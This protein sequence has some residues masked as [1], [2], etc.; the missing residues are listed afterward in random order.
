MI[1]KYDVIIIGGGPGGSTAGA[2]L[3]QKSL[4]VALF[5]RETYPRFHIGESLLPAS[6]PILKQSGFYPTLSNGKYIE[7]Y[8]ARFVD[9]HTD[10]EVYFGFQDG[11]SQDLPMAFEVERSD[12][13]RDILDH[14]RKSGVDVFQPERVK[15][16][17]LFDSH[18]RV[19]TNRDQYEAKFLIDATGRD[20]M[21]GKQQKIRT[22]NRDLNN[23]AVFAHF[24]GVKRLEGKDEGDILIGLLPDRAWNWI[25]PFKGEKTSV[26]VVCSSSQFNGGADLLDYLTTS[27]S[28]S[29]RV[30]D[31]MK[32]AEKS[33][34][35]T[36][37]SN[38]SHTCETLSGD[39]WILI[40]DAA[41]FL[42]P[43]FSSGVH[44]SL[45]SAKFASETII[46]ALDKGI[47]LNQENL[48]NNYRDRLFLGVKR[49][50]NLISMFYQGGFVGQMKKTN[51]L[52][53]TR[54]GF[55]SAVAGD[56]WNENNFLF[57]K[58]IL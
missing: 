55:T 8:G 15:E 32:N 3:A 22:V 45:S 9:C 10:D 4:K 28:Q 11:I 16:I 30:R 20:A 48:G 29:P 12:F 33:S 24:H 14:A 1:H 57:Q 2:L 31:Y 42:D 18:V 7:K 17:E 49:F 39:R 38:Y 34:E 13:D 23:V 53:H 37:I 43:I 41:V 21:L 40:G 44:V 35:I 26:G 27:L 47:T 6:M 54:Q 50:H 51:T 19:K 56:M 52:K 25:I 58:G 46:E 5:E 36:V